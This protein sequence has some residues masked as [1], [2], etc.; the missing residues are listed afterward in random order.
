MA[1]LT[2]R[3]LRVVNKGRIQILINKLIQGDRSPFTTTN[4]STVGLTKIAFTELG[5]VKE[6]KNPSNPRE[7]HE[8][9]QKLQSGSMKGANV[10]LYNDKVRFSLNDILR[11]EEF[12]GG[13]TSKGDLAELVFSAAIV[14]RFNNKNTT[15]SEQDVLDLINTLDPNRQ[16]QTFMFKSVNKNAN[17][18]DNIRWTI[19]TPMIN[20]KA[21][22][23]AKSQQ[24]LSDMV[25]ASVKYA[26]SA[27]VVSWAKLFYENNRSNNIEVTASGKIIQ[28][29]NKVDIYITADKKRINLNSGVGADQ[30]KQLGQ[31]GGATYEKQEFLWNTLFGI[32]PKKYKDDYY[33]QIK[34]NQPMMAIASIYKGMV[35]DINSA[36]SNNKQK[37]YD[38]VSD[39]I[40]YFSTKSDKTI[41]MIPLT[42]KESNVYKFNNLTTVLGLTNVKMRAIYAGKAYPQVDFINEKGKVLFSI[43]C[44][45][46]NNT[47]RNYIVKGKLVTE[48][49]SV[50]A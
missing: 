19:N 50:L 44:K 33:T 26:N 12:G 1:A 29:E 16:T 20:I 21:V 47:V 48:L 28:K 39:G 11:T 34:A 18:Y 42:K 43:Q 32:P 24:A 45:L 3:D 17:I 31:I 40:N 2:L 35:S 14:S 46:E 6:Y 4:G 13:K 25:Q 49:A 5:R 27:S 36:I 10:I 30:K 8:I 23:D 7:M 38:T 22:S 41:T 15:V 37:V 9:M